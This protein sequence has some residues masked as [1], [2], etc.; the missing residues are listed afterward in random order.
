MMNEATRTL[1]SVLQW[2]IHVNGTVVVA[3]KA[4]CSKQLGQW[5]VQKERHSAKKM[6]LEIMD[7]HKKKATNRNT[8]DKVQ[9]HR[10]LLNYLTV[11]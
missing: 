1:F 7:R 8:H 10:H 4:V 11:K 2:R 3:I 9:L 6:C 5:G